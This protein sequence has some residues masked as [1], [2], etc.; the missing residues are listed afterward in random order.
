MC[1]ELKFITCIPDEI[2]FQWEVKSYLF[3]LREF[4]Y[5]QLTEI[6]IYQNFSNSKNDFSPF[7]Y[8]LQDEY[9]EVKFFFYKDVDN[10]ERLMRLF[11]YAPLSR[12]YMLCKHFE[13]Y[14]NLS[15]NAV[16]YTDS[17]IIFL[18]KIDFTPFLK[19]DICY[20]SDTKT[21]I[22]A[23]YFDSK[24]KDVREDKLL[25][26]KKRDILNE[27][28]E[29]AGINRDVCVKNN[30]KSGGAQ[31]LLKNI[32]SSFW[33]KVLLD[34]LS[35]KT[36]LS[37]VNQEFIKGDTPQD[38]EN[39]GTQIWCSDMFSLL[40]NLWGRGL[41]TECPIELNF[42]WATDKIVENGFAILHNAG[43]TGEEKIRAT[44]DNKSIKD[45]SGL[46]ILIE[47]PA[48]FKN[49]YNKNFP[50]R[51]ELIKITENN[52]SKKFYTSVYSEHLLKS[53]F[54]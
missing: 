43:V 36:H 2:R 34:C 4:E 17:D 48:F 46:P 1:K 24:I 45:E 7:W 5:S 52:I 15:K 26:Y 51:E 20:L 49:K 50:E 12:L 44:Q 11:N 31:Y 8:E 37:N 32:D 40:W 47:A 29:F 9:K 16:F 10:F 38:R 19:D 18:K 21:Y 23:D 6:L 53:I 54:K 39:N 14:P 13:A 41:E 27:V 30:N 25:E 42:H 22:N 33:N 3:S 35:I 28:V